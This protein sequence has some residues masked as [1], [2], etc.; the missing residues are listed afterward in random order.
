VTAIPPLERRTGLP[1][2]VAADVLVGYFRS[3]YNAATV[4]RRLPPHITVL[5]P[6][7]RGVDVAATYG[8]DLSAHFASFEPFAAELTGVGQFDRFVWLAPEPRERFVELV[9]TTCA[10]FPEFPPYEEEGGEPEPHLTVGAVD[11]SAPTEPVA[12]AARAELQPRLPFEFA[13][14]SVWLFGEQ[15]DGTFEATTRYGLG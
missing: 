2:P 1:I 3:R 4:A 12:R 10:R 9:R 8:A 7:A 13:V 11:A 15:E 14:D 6:F 5:F